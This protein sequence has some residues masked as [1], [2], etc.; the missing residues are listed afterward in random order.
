MSTVTLFDWDYESCMPRGDWASTFNRSSSG[1]I[2]FSI[3]LYSGS[4]QS[5]ISHPKSHIHVWS[6]VCFAYHL[7][8]FSQTP[9]KDI[10]RGNLV[11]HDFSAESS[12][13]VY[14]L[15]FNDQTLSAGL[16]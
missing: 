4:N 6:N 1:W 11:N 14:L 2:C 9:E 7:G 13:R 3:D 5:V 16:V 12:F 15:T 10:L 8:I